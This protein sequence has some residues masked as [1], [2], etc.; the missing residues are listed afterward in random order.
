MEELDTW[1]LCPCREWLFVPISCWSWSLLSSTSSCAV[2]I[3]LKLALDFSI[4]RLDWISRFAVGCLLGVACFVCVLILCRFGGSSIDLFWAWILNH[5]D[6]TV[7]V[8]LVIA[9]SII[10]LYFRKL[11]LDVIECKHIASCL[12]LRRGWM[13][14]A[15]AC[16]RLWLNIH[17]FLLVDKLI[18]ICVRYI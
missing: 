11:V 6:L 8:R 13:S 2:K 10:L 7:A 4:L 12:V 3:G 18:L 9:S 14:E 5:V 15:L 16:L 17:N 1:R